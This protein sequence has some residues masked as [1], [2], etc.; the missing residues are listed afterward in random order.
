MTQVFAKSAMTITR[1]SGT[2]MEETKKYMRPGGSGSG[3]LYE[4]D[5][6]FVHRMKATKI[7]KKEDHTNLLLA[8]LFIGA[9]LLA[10]AVAYKFNLHFI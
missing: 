10:Y 8:I 3:G 6:E 4:I 9:L 2:N 5:T 7:V 1:I